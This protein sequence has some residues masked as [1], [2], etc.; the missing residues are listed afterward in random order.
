MPKVRVAREPAF[1]NVFTQKIDYLKIPQ[2]PRRNYNK[3]FSPYRYVD[4]LIRF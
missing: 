3:Q 2:T 1:F 4:S